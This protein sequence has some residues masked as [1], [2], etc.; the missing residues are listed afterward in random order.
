VASSYQVVQISTV[1]LNPYVRLLQAALSEAGIPCSTAERLEPLHLPLAHGMGNILHLHWLE[2]LYAVPFPKSATPVH[3]IIWWGRTIRRLMA[4]LAGLARAKAKGAKIVY[5]VHN[6][7]PHEQGSPAINRM[8]NR[9]LFALADALHVHDDQAKVGAARV[10]G[11][12]DRIWVVPHGS[13]I[14][15]YPND[16]TRQQARMKLGL[17]PDAFVYLCLGQIR[18]YKGIEDLIAAF[19]Q[20]P[21][22]HPCQLLLAG[23]VHEQAYAQTLA[24][25]T[26][27]QPS[28]HTCFQYV[29][30]A[31]LQCF[32]NAC[33][34]CV[35]PYR[36]ITTS[37][38][39]I[40][41]FS[42]GKPV[43]APA[44]GGF[45]E[46]LADGR[47]IVYDPQR[48][49]GL[50]RA[51]QEARSG[52]IEAAGRQALTWAKEHEWRMLAPRFM[53][54]YETV[55]GAGPAEPASASVLGRGESS[56]R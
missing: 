29:E 13:Y 37:G 50:L 12:P 45:A 6:L 53:H 8:A 54:I 22:S 31:E 38:A 30:D 42:F 5:T 33:D 48:G 56:S 2:L 17:A 3:M 11:R 26:Q 19:R 9:V 1:R 7:S 43:I 41:A 36:D 32:L 49:D 27:G 47:G 55:L 21:A 18:R 10:Y 4:V 24:Q 52:D 46:L 23:H 40:L 20:L 14:G 34:V 35:L 15:A 25:L 51:L 39:A 16:C 44:L 28:I